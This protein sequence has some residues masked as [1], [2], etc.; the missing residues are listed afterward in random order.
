MI[1]LYGSYPD[2]GYALSNERTVA[3]LSG[4][5]GRF[6][7][8]TTV[9][10]VTQ[11][12][13]KGNEVMLDLLQ[14]AIQTQSDPSFK[15]RQWETVKLLFKQAVLVRLQRVNALQTQLK[16]SDDETFTAVWK[17]TIDTLIKAESLGLAPDNSSLELNG[18]YGLMGLTSYGHGTRS[19]KV[20]YEL[21]PASSR[22]IN[23]LA[24]LR[25][26]LWTR[27][28]ITEHPAV[29]TLSPPWPRGLPIQ[30]HWFLGKDPSGWR[31]S[32]RIDGEEKSCDIPPFLEKRVHEV[33]FMQPE[34]A[35]SAVPSDDEIQSAIGGFID[36]Y[37]LAL[38]LYL[39]FGAPDLKDK[40]LQAAWSHAIEQLSGDRMLPIERRSYW[41]E[42]FVGCGR[43]RVILDIHFG[44]I[45]RPQAS[46]V[47][48][49]YD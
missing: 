32:V 24:V 8:T 39:S 7:T 21:C 49:R 44:R 30:A 47:R 26:S 29:T 40:R 1:E 45:S 42:H 23:E 16:L 13:R 28:R 14:S 2:G 3:L 34:Q 33:V 35:F 43:N 38:S 10:N 19:P 46:H 48:R 37:R 25:E 36:D 22:F 18:M 41:R 12:V 27:H 17:D 11:N 31:T 5:P 9:Q 6:K 20:V 4:M 15:P